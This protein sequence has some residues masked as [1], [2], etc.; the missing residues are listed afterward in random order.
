MDAATAGELPA[1]TQQED[2]AAVQPTEPGLVPGTQQD[3]LQQAFEESG[4]SAEPAAGAEPELTPGELVEQAVAQVHGG[5]PD[6]Q[7]TTADAEPFPPVAG[8]VTST[9]ATPQVA[10]STAVVTKQE[11][12]ENLPPLGSCDNPIQLIQQGNSYHSIQPLS[13]EQLQQITHALQQ[14]QVAKAIQTSG[15]AVSYHPQTHTR[16]IYRV[17]YPERKDKKEGI[18]PVSTAAARTPK[19]TKLPKVHPKGYKGRGRPAKKYDDDINPEG[20]SLTKEEREAL[21]KQVPRTR[22]GRI[23]RPPKYMVRDYKR[24]HHLD[25][26]EEPPPDESDGGYSDIEGVEVGEDGIKRKR[27][28]LVVGTDLSLTGKLK[29]YRCLQCDRAY[30][31]ELRLRKHFR[32]TQHG[33]PDN[34]PPPMNVE[35]IVQSDEDGEEAENQRHQDQLAEAARKEREEKERRKTQPRSYA[36]MVSTRRKNRLRESLRQCTD[37]EVLDVCLY[38]VAQSATMWQFLLAKSEDG[39]PP[40]PDVS[41]M[42]V[43]LETLLQQ[44]ERLGREFMTPTNDTEGDDLVDLVDEMVAAA[45]GNK[46][47]GMYRIEREAYFPETD[48]LVK[49]HPV[50]RP[51]SSA[52]HRAPV[53]VPASANTTNSGSGL[54][55]PIISH[56]ASPLH[57]NTPRSV[58]Q[59]SIIVNH[60]PTPVA[61]SK[62][63]MSHMGMMAPPSIVRRTG[64]IK[65]YI[66]QPQSA[67]TMTPSR[68]TPNI[69]S[70]PKPQFRVV[71][72]APR[73]AS[74]L[75]R[76]QPGASLLRV[77]FR[78]ASMVRSTRRWC[79]QILAMLCNVCE[80]EVSL[81]VGQVYEDENGQPVVINEDG[82]VTPVSLQHMQA[83]EVADTAG[84][85]QA[86]SVDTAGLMEAGGQDATTTSVPPQTTPSGTV[87]TSST[88]MQQQE[89]IQKVEPVDEVLLQE[90]AALEQAI[91]Q[92]DEASTEETQGQEEASTTTATVTAV[93]GEGEA[94]VALALSPD[95]NGQMI[96]QIVLA[97]GH[98]LGTCTS[99][100][101][102][103][104]GEGVQLLQQEDGQAL[105]QSAHSNIQVPLDT[106]RVLL[107]MEQQNIQEG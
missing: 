51:P 81:V 4:A 78:S 2:A 23:S 50:Y 99:S 15:S 83:H 36:D 98:V 45:L 56:V 105:L 35:E 27:R 86:E 61:V 34:L 65:S 94:A 9:P 17:I 69:L 70:S 12:Q 1:A 67:V 38:R 75:N 103:S 31:S 64:N 37:K 24:I 85:G 93:I 33:D 80:E 22:S 63:S 44:T 106:V 101:E 53:R 82:T 43:N 73:G 11:Q 21:K 14:Q 72:A 76:P 97:D 47:L 74:H 66:P 32:L 5:E 18:K 52:R 96:K 87:V 68:M 8:P 28:K 6:A 107:H 16:V 104:L 71:T 60:R 7:D 90:G 54:S 89:Q 26:H 10:S 91:L 55:R 3:I 41:M 79:F 58:V 42:L 13:P 59:P 77:K 19:A 46:S 88:T 30:I 20:P 39:D 102:L 95:A 100:G 25:F 40:V 49:A 48:F 29:A 84:E 92:G 57:K 62:M